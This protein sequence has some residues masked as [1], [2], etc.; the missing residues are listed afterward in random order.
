MQLKN[1]KDLN[2]RVSS[3][4]STIRGGNKDMICIGYGIDGAKDLSNTFGI[5]T[6][7]LHQYIGSAFH[8]RYYGSASSE[9][10]F[11]TRAFYE[12]NVKDGFTH[13]IQSAITLGEGLVGKLVKGDVDTFHVEYFNL[14]TKNS[15]I[16]FWMPQKAKDIIATRGWIVMVE[17]AS[18]YSNAETASIV[19]NTIVLNDT[20]TASVEDENVIVGCQT[21]PSAKVLELAELINNLAK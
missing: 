12:A 8:G 2:A 6:K 14:Y 3:F 1:L 9:L 5:P 11:I 18:K 19:E 16:P 7:E 13:T 10:Y 17:N 15:H 4:S 20:Y 21:I